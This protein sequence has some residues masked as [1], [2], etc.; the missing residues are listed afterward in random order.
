MSVLGFNANQVRT[1]AADQDSLA[2]QQPS[3]DFM[4][5]DSYVNEISLERNDA[6][7]E[8]PENIQIQSGDR[9]TASL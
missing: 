2:T 4:S 8:F 9:N 3:D 5:I 1:I 6:Q 7:V